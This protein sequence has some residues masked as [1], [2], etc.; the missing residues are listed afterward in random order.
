MII[1]PIFILYL[2][3]QTTKKAKI[4]ILPRAQHINLKSSFEVDFRKLVLLT[5]FNA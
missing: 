1:I 2:L 4:D 5:Q 3:L